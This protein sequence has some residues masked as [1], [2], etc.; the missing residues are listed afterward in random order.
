MLLFVYRLQKYVFLLKPP[1]NLSLFS[2]KSYIIV[3]TSL[4]RQRIHPICEVHSLFND[5]VARKTTALVVDAATNDIKQLAGDGLL[6]RLVVLQVK[7]AQQ[8][9]CIIRSCLHGYHTGCVL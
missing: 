4:Y 3:F 7:L 2:Q 8:F 9:V 5:A 6:T 1:N